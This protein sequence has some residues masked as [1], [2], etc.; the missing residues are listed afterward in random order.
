M[1]E[2]TELLS[3]MWTDLIARPEGPFGFRLFLQPLVAALLAWPFVRRRLRFATV[4]L[5][6]VLGFLPSGLLDVC[7]S[8]GTHWLWPLYGE[9][10]AWNL[11]AIIDP[12]FT[13]IL[14]GAAGL[15]AGRG[16]APAAAA[17]AAPAP[18][19]TAGSAP[20]PRP[21]LFTPKAAPQTQPD[22]EVQAATATPQDGRYRGDRWCIA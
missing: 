10:L 22:P 6:A 12:L 9:R 16:A 20:A 1:S 5:L 2:L 4:Y 8:F 21:S 19:A 15:C 13:L 7:T 17:E 3:R 11:I 18:G 14:L